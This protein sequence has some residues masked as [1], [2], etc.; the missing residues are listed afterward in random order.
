[1]DMQ[2]QSPQEDSVQSHY[3]SF[4]GPVYAWSTGGIDAAIERG[5]TEL[6][7]L[8]V[9]DTQ[10]G[11]LAVDLGAGFGTHSIPLAHMGWRVLAL[12]RCSHTCS[13]NFGKLL[14]PYPFNALKTIYWPL[15]IIWTIL[16][17]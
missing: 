11:N 13:K 14:G 16:R 1:M 2:R 17:T 10:A 6:K 8:G 12:D 5:D 4:L 9:S 3:D 7:A 15:T